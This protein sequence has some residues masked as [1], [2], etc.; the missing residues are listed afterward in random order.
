MTI[1]PLCVAEQPRDLLDQHAVIRQQGH[2]GVPQI[3]RRPLVRID[4]VDG[5]EH[6]AVQRGQ[7][8]LSRQVAEPGLAETFSDQVGAVPVGLPSRLRKVAAGLS[9]PV[10][11]AFSD[12]VGGAGLDAAL[13]LA[14]KITELVLDDGSWSAR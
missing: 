1:E 12:R 2:E 9:E 10:V 8:M 7:D 3:P 4:P 13:D 5:F 11:E 14:A 6:H